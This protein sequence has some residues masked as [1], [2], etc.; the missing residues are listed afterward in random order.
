MT[1]DRRP[2]PQFLPVQHVLNSTEILS[3]YVS[4]VFRNLNINKSCG[5]DLVS[6]RLLKEAG[7][8]LIRPLSMIFNRSSD[9]GYFPVHWKLAMCAQ[10]I[11]KTT[12]LHLLTRGLLLY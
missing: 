12:N 5:P 8:V 9:Q 10:F 4:D 3:Q 1:D 6:P 11:K 2:L 7:S